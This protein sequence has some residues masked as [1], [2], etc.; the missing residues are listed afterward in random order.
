MGRDIGPKLLE[1]LLSVVL[2][3]TRVGVLVSPTSTTYISTD[4]NG[5]REAEQKVGTRILL[6]EVRTP[7][8]IEEAFAMLS[9]ENVG[10]I[11][12]SASALLGAQGQ[13]I[14]DLSN[15]YR[16]ASI[17]GNGLSAEAGALMEYVGSRSANFLR[18]ASYVDKILEGVKPWDLPVEQ[19]ETFELVVNF[20][21]AKALGLTIPQ[22]VLLRADEV[23][24]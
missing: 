21:T 24:E 10:A 12:V 16:L 2:K 11:I 1:L 14:A 5:L 4:W 8:E 13:Q 17:S 19:S 20:R 23:I 7:Q 3:A 18:A 6:A 22:A 9:R 15:K